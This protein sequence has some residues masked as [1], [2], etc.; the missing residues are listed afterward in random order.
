MASS[1]SVIPQGRLLQ[2]LQGPGRQ[3]QEVVWAQW[4]VESGR[5]SGVWEFTLQTCKVRSLILQVLPKR[6]SQ[7][8]YMKC[9]DFQMLDQF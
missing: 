3:W 6:R 9:H 8:L 7:D 5:D 4:V 1:H 2:G